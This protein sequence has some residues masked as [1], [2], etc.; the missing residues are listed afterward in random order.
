MRRK[1]RPCQTKTDINITPYI[2]ILLVLLIIFMVLQPLEQFD[3]EARI[4]ERP[5]ESSVQPAPAIVLSIDA[6]FRMEINGE[7]VGLTALGRRLFEIF[8]RRTA[9]SLFIRADKDLAFGTA[10]GIID[11]AKGAGVGDVGLMTY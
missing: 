4:P 11:I 2:D 8:S 1:T 7:R 9:K 10:A 6:N 3:L 5:E